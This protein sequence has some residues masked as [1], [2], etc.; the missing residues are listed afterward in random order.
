MFNNKDNMENFNKTIKTN[1]AEPI[2][3]TNLVDFFKNLFRE[4]EEKYDILNS[5]ENLEEIKQHI[6]M[7]LEVS[8]IKDQQKAY[9]SN[10]MKEIDDYARLLLFFQQQILGI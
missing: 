3:N 4:V 9:Y 6:I 10:E 7:R 1:V 2:A 8:K 5:Y